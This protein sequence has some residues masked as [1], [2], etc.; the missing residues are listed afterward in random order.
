MN[1]IQDILDGW[2]YQPGELN[3]RRIESSD[4]KQ[5]IQLRLDM[6]LLQ[7]AVRGRPDGK[8]PMG[9][10]SLLEFHQSQLV[11][12]CHRHGTDDGF[13]LDEPSCQALRSEGVMYYHRYLA[14]FV[15]NDFMLVE[16]DT[17]RNLAMFDFCH[18]YASDETTRAYVQQY[19]PYVLM[20]NARARTRRAMIENDFAAAIQAVDDAM[21][22]I[23]A[24]YQQWGGDDALDLSPELAILH[25]LRHEVESL[26]PIDP[27]DQL[28]EDLRQAIDEERYED[29]ATLRDQLRQV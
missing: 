13:T 20:M 10:E 5:Y 17:Q 24:S 16:S 19:R 22:D 4:G 3:V 29:A 7:M 14:A 9:F 6:G 26:Q 8:R 2:N 27:R 18:L 15:L 23:E 25:A 21:L 28:Q 12:Y 11:D 1:N